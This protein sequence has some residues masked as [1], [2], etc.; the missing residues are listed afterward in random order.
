MKNL[1]RKIASAI[2]PE[3]QIEFLVAGDGV[4]RPFQAK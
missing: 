2:H 1:M 4:E 3:D